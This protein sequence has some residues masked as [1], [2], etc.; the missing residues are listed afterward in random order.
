MLYFHYQGERECYMKKIIAAATIVLLLCEAMPIAASAYWP[1][2]FMRDGTQPSDLPAFNSIIWDA[3]NDPEYLHSIDFD[4]R[5]FVSIR[6]CSAGV[7]M[8]KDAED[9]PWEYNGYDTVSKKPTFKVEPGKVYEVKIV[10]HNNAKASMNFITPEGTPWADTDS[11]DNRRVGPS[12]A[13]DTKVTINLYQSEQSD[14]IAPGVLGKIRGEISAGNAVVYSLDGSIMGDTN[15]NLVEDNNEIWQRSVQDEVFFYADQA[16][17]MRFVPAS[18]RHYNNFQNGTLL[19]SSL[20]NG[21]DINDKQLPGSG[22]SITTK[23]GGVPGWIY[24]CTENIGY[25]TVRVMAVK[26]D[27]DKEVATSAQAGGNTAEAGT[28]KNSWWTELNN[29]NNFLTATLSGVLAALIA[30][31]II[32]LISKRK[33]DK[34]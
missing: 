24:G 13:Q 9:I 17:A 31:G 14:S 32:A 26:I 28:N 11:E 2:R 34:K 12:I 20:I 8:S 7:D 10:Y 18:A 25:I 4:E 27:E 19:P 6:E 16:V 22:A 1:E 3:E 33:K 23:E 21:Y 5:N 29:M 30:A 15:Q